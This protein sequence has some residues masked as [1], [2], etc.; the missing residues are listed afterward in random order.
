[1]ALSSAPSS[2]EELEERSVRN[3]VAPC[4]SMIPGLPD[5]V[6]IQCLAR[7]PFFSWKTVRGVATAWRSAFREGSI[8]KTREVLGIKEYMIILIVRLANSMFIANVDDSSRVRVALPFDTY[9]HPT[10]RVCP[11]KVG[12][13]VF[14]EAYWS[15]PK[16]ID[17]WRYNIMTNVWLK[18]VSW[19]GSFP[20]QDVFLQRV[21]SLGGNSIL[22][23]HVG[24]EEDALLV[25][26]NNDREPKW[27]VLNKL[28]GA[29]AEGNVNEIAFVKWE[30]GLVIPR[31]MFG[32]DKEGLWMLTRL[33]FL[34]EYNF[35]QSKSKPLWH[36]ECLYVPVGKEREHSSFDRDE[37]GW[38]LVVLPHQEM[39]RA[40]E[41]GLQEMFLR[42]RP[43]LPWPDPIDSTRSSPSPP[44][45]D[46]LIHVGH[47]LF[48]IHWH[49]QILQEVVNNDGG[50]VEV[51]FEARAL[52]GIWGMEPYDAFAGVAC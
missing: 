12:V 19:Q 23:L 6:S 14:V 27:T 2:I 8:R 46:S 26:Y 9:Q 31:S 20:S 49:S 21:A 7:V 51:V 38:K 30:V 32:T 41:D 18:G 11:S 50:Q 16:C 39:L 3:E 24:G 42:P 33:N 29:M 22:E 13:D 47:R 35:A 44:F 5:D 48:A 34:P 43:L 25:T 40:S 52:V 36:G 4:Q 28:N 10:F 1:M 17:V 15:V 37:R 45:V